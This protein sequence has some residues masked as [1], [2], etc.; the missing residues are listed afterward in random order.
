MLSGSSSEQIP[1]IPI[2]ILRLWGT[3]S[4]TQK[5][6]GKDAKCAKRLQII[7]RAQMIFIFELE[8]S[9]AHKQK[10]HEILRWAWNGWQ[11]ID[12]MWH[13][14]KEN[15]LGTGSMALRT[16]WQHGLQ[17]TLLLRWDVKTRSGSPPTKVWKKN[18][19]ASRQCQLG[20]VRLVRP[21][22]VLPRTTS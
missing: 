12:G 18:N 3:Q 8:L 10:P 11:G 2:H 20:V 21:K 1:P 22:Y 15:L 5:T 7:C 9:L 4:A 16:W 14:N 17:S 6:L 13:V 19:V